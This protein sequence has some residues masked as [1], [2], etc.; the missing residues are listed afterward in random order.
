MGG[1]A[2]LNS[3]LHP[4]LYFLEKGSGGVSR[5]DFSPICAY[6]N[7]KYLPLLN[8][9]HFS[10]HFEAFRLQGIEIHSAWQ[11]RCILSH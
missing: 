3:P 5:I 10:C 9:H 6:L 4:P 8:Q 1:I 11:F 2:C 7:K